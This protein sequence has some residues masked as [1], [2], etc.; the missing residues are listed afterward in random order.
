MRRRFLRRLHGAPRR[1]GTA[2]VHD[3]RQ[4]GGRRARDHHRRPFLRWPAPRA[5]RVGGDRRRAVRLLSGRPD[6][7]GG[8]TS[9]THA[10]A[11]RRRHSDG[12]DRQHLPLRD[13]HADSARGSPGVGDCR[14]VLPGS[15]ALMYTR[16]DVLRANKRGEAIRRAAPSRRMFLKV[17]ASAAGGLLVSIGW[18]RAD[19]RTGDATRF[20]SAQSSASAA[21][22][23][24]PNAFVRIDPDDTITIWSRNPDMGE[25]VKTSLSMIIADE[26][27]ADWTRVR[28][29]NAALERRYGPQGVG[30]SDAVSSAWDDHRRAGATARQLIVAA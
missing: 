17:S 13:V 22:L 23:F 26:L 24:Q 18:D 19:A 3:A 16:E 30:G 1:P 4:S 8:R 7:D 20:G 12:D 2:I 29:E 28:I 5:T 9:R 25:G 6:H 14:C 10:G 11:V 21:P 15:G 27:D